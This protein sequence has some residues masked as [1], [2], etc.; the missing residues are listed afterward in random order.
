MVFVRAR[1]VPISGVILKSALTIEP[2]GGKG[3]VVR[4]ITPHRFI[5]D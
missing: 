4:K 1:Y 3:L 2:G 5:P